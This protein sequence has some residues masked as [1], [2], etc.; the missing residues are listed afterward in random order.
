MEESINGMKITN[1]T[2]YPVKKLL[3]KKM[4]NTDNATLIKTVT[5]GSGKNRFRESLY[6]SPRGDYF[7]HGKGGPLTRWSGG[8]DLV[9]I[10]AFTL[11]LWLERYD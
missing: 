5:K 11:K 7:L 6:L 2:V 1:V 10:S 8:E 3:K 9:V 4:Y